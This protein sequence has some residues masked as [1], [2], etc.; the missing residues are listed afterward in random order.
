MNS[1]NLISKNVPS[2]DAG[3]G[4]CN[5][6]LYFVA[7]S[8][9]LFVALLNTTPLVEYLGKYNVIY[10]TVPVL[11]LIDEIRNEK[12]TSSDA[13][14]LMLFM[15]AN[16]QT[17]I[18]G[19]NNLAAFSMFLYCSRDK[20]YKDILILTAAIDALVLLLVPSLVQLNIIDDTTNIRPDGTIRTS[21]GFSY[22][23]YASYVLL[24]LT[25][26]G[27]LLLRKASR[28]EVL[29]FSGLVL[30]A[31]AYLFIKTNA[32]NGF[33]LTIASVIA[34]TYIILAQPRWKA[35]SFGSILLAN[36]H[37]LAFLG[38]F[39]LVAVYL[40]IPENS[41]L[42]TINRL[43]SHRL[44]IT[45]Y[46]LSRFGFPVIGGT[47][48]DLVAAGLVIDSS[49]FRIIYEHGAIVLVAILAAL[50]ISQYIIIKHGDWLLYAALSIVAVHSVFDAQLISIQHNVLI[51][52]IAYLINT[53]TDV[54]R[55][56]SR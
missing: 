54:N 27:Y 39:A 44:E 1:S 6:P 7:Y 8:A 43:M 25:L 56:T 28:K 4:I 22:V 40:F 20:K 15:V 2:Y 46:A 33:L 26:T 32:R 41:F 30:A 17:W 38:F 37:T 42:E 45:A 55:E 5:A 36:S 48:E 51:L 29:I 16:V 47:N 18:V 50:A 3:R 24:N 19:H 11:L 34:C 53:K 21:L 52:I 9:W 23:T 13:K 31:N 35:K 49:F 14:V 10:F 12:H